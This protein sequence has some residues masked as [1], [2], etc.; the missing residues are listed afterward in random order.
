MQQQVT[1]AGFSVEGHSKTEWELQSLAEAL[2]RRSSALRQ[3]GAE[4]ILR[5]IWSVR[6]SLYKITSDVEQ[7]AELK[8]F[9]E[10]FK[11]Q[12]LE[13][14]TRKNKKGEGDAFV[15]H[16]FD[17]A[18]LPGN[19][20]TKIADL[21]GQVQLRSSQSCVNPKPSAKLCLSHLHSQTASS[22]RCYRMLECTRAAY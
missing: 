14:W 21:L 11:Q 22:F 7:A 1:F 2:T 12:V 5:Q 3:E 15:L 16:C 9:H 4:L 19:I 13:Q 18:I 6:S 8:L 17:T 20:L 10:S